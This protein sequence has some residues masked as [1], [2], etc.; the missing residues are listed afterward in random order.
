MA[1]ANVMAKE[2]R[3]FQKMAGLMWLLVMIVGASEDEDEEFGAE[4]QKAFVTFCKYFVILR[5]LV[6]ILGS[7]ENYQ[8][9]LGWEVKVSNFYLGGNMVLI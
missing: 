3:C 2:G 6:N 7:L 8:K 5:S 4:L 9:I 1:K